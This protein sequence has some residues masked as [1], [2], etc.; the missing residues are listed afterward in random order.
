MAKPSEII[1]NLGSSHVSASKLNVKSGKLL[2]EKFNLIELPVTS[3][4]E[5]EWF[6]SV[7]GAISELSSKFGFKGDASI[8]L[9]GSMVLIKNL[10]SSKS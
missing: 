1:F 4:E 3:G 10:E 7:E 2:L 5:Q 9:P 6:N 8:I